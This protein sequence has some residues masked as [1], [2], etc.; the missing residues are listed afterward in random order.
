MST[1]Y[2][3]KLLQSFALLCIAILCY[4]AGITIKTASICIINQCSDLSLMVLHNRYPLR[5]RKDFSILKKNKHSL[6][7][8]N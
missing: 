2:N 6:E 1:Y 5:K 3:N 7:H 4:Q 8:S